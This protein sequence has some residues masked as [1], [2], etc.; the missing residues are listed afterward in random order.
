MEIQELRKK[1][2]AIDDQLARLFKERMDVSLS[3]A[4][5]KKENKLPVLDRGREREVLI[6]VSDIVGEDYQGYAK[7]LYRTLFDMSR[8]AQLMAIDGQSELTEAIKT[9]VAETPAQFPQRATVACQGVEG[10]YSQQA[11]D[12]LFSLA[13][14]M[15]FNRFDGVFQAVNAGLCQYGI[16][17]IEN[18][19]AGSV[20]EVYDLMK[21]YDF[22]I[23]RSV[24]LKVDHALL[25]MGGVKLANVR[26][27][28]S[29]QQAISQCSKFLKANP[30]IKVTVMEN[31][32]AAAKYVAGSG[33]RDVAAIASVG[34]AELYGLQILDEGIQDTDHNYTRFICISKKMQIFPGAN[35]I[36]LMLT[37]PH[38]PG[39]LYA[40]ISK[41]S[42]L[43]LNLNKLESRPM[44]GKDFEFMFYF[45]LEASP[46]APE[47]LNILAQMEKELTSFSFLG[48][49]QEIF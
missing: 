6:R 7:I 2:D 19:A 25:A 28:V 43:G 8:S 49:Y 34:C 10:A 38:R 9:A 37:V 4:Q 18:S 40:V 42:S 13:D 1:I 12:K 5:Y 20:T 45:D 24:K 27:V 11:C 31:T 15:Y 36:S 14:V 29:H 41:F 21:K 32:A 16:L 48:G 39:S 46:S 47:L 17:P 22:Y 26:E 30:Q 3:I 33:R 23:C 35:R 44:A